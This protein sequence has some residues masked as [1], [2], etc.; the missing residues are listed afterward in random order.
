MENNT[1]NPYQATSA[2]L[3][4]SVVEPFAPASRGHRMGASLIDALLMMAIALPIAYFGFQFNLFAEQLD[5]HLEL[6][7]GA[8]LFVVYLILNGYWL[9]KDGQTIGKKLCAIRVVRSDNSPAT[10]FTLVVVRYLPWAIV[11]AFEVVSWLAFIDVLFIFGEKRQCLH[12]MIADTKV[13]KV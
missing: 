12:D 11:S 4:H 10:F 8:I 2:S 5:W 7:F 3:E 6:A 9:Q 1:L 13:I